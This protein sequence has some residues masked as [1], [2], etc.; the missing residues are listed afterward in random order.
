MATV[1]LEKWSFSNQIRPRALCVMLQSA[2]NGQLPNPLS[3]RA[4]LRCVTC[5]NISGQCGE[6]T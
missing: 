3:R 6:E 5:K 4:A 2:Y 1:E